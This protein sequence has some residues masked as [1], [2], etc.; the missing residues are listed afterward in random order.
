MDLTNRTEP[1][2]VPP[3]LPKIPHRI[4]VGWNWGFTVRD[5]RLTA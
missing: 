3:G 2:A 5:R 4:D 1:V